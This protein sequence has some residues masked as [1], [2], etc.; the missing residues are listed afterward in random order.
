VDSITAVA[1]VFV[2]VRAEA[3]EEEGGAFALSTPWLVLGC[4]RDREFTATA[5]VLGRAVLATD[6]REEEA[7]AVGIW[8]EEGVAAAVSPQAGG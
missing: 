8:S 5:L 6:R 3:E 4:A 1:L 2:L 7:A